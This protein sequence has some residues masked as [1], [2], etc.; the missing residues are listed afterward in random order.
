[1]SAHPP[2]DSF[3]PVPADPAFSAYASAAHHALVADRQS[4]SAP[5]SSDSFSPRWYA[6][7]PI[8]TPLI[9]FGML[10]F[11]AAGLYFVERRLI[12]ATGESLALMAAG[13][14]DNIDRLMLERYV[15][16]QMMTKTLRTRPND[17]TFLNNYIA[18]TKESYPVYSWLGVTDA[19]GVMIATS[20][21]TILGQNLSGAQWFQS[22]RWSNGPRLNDVENY[23]TAGGV[24]SVGFSAPITDQAGTFLGAVTTRVGLPVIEDVV[25]QTLRAFANRG[26][27]HEGLEYQVLTKEGTAFI[28]SDLFHKG[29][30]NL[31]NLGLP[32]AR[33]SASPDPGYVEEKHVRRHEPVITG[34]A[35][36]RGFDEFPELKWRVL[37]RLDRSALLAPINKV[38]W[39]LSVAGAVVLAPL[40]GFL[41]LTTRRLHREWRHA[42]EAEASERLSEVRTRLLLETALDAIIMLDPGGRVTAWNNQAE[43]TFGWTRDEAIGQDMSQLIIPAHYREAHR[44]GLLRYLTAGD[45]SMLYKR[46]ELTAHDRRGREF[47]V[48]MTV[49]PAR[50]GSMIFF[51]AFIREI[52]ERKQAERRLACQYAVASVLAEAHSVTEATPRI[53]EAVCRGLGGWDLAVLWKVDRETDVLRCASIWPSTM[54][55]DR[56][57]ATQTRQTTFARGVGLPGRVWQSRQPLWIEDV[58]AD[59]N[60]P[61]APFA[62]QAGLHGGLAF[63]ICLG[64]EIVGVMEF[65]SHEIRESEME[66]LHTLTTIGGQIGQCLTREQDQLRLRTA[67]EEAQCAN[68]AKSEFVANM[69]HEIRTPMNGI[70]GMTELLLDTSLSRDQY[71][72]AKTV[73]ASAEALLV[74]LND[75]LDFSKIEA[76]KLDLHP[77]PLSLRDTLSDALSAVALRAHQKGIELIGHVKPDVP[78]HLIGDP[79]RLRQI[80]INL[81]GN[82]LK[83]TEHGEVVVEVAAMNDE[84]GTINKQSKSE[85]S[86]SEVHR[87]S[88]ITLRFSVRDTG[89][90]IPIEQQRRIFDAFT[91][92]D[93][94]TTRKYGGTGLGLTITRK[95]VEMMGGR[96]F[97]ESQ[98]GKGST[99]TFTACFVPQPAS[100][101]PVVTEAPALAGLPVLVVDD[102]DTN[103]RILMELLGNWK[104]RPHAVHSGEAALAALSA[105]ASDAPYALCVLDVQMPEMDGWTLA[106]RIR[107]RPEG[108]DVGIL[109][110]TSEGTNGSESRAQAL[111][112]VAVL[113]KPIRQ[114][115][116]LDA[117][118]KLCARGGYGSLPT[119]VESN[120]APRREATGP[121]PNAG[122]RLAILLV[123]DNVVNQRLALRLLEKDGHSVTIAENGLDAL[124]LFETQTVDLILMD[125][126]MPVMDGFEAT[127]AIRAREAQ[128]SEASGVRGEVT[129]G[130]N[131]SS[132]LTPHASPLSP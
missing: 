51:G 88:F 70:L 10:L 63:P 6:W 48:E 30:V 119:L 103:L 32:S 79:V 60:F 112:P 37:V 102:N 99:F 120:T 74:I 86:A 61:R 62:S 108:R 2:N 46:V 45:E 12:A 110:L 114:S 126:Q 59:P 35:R 9:V 23:E 4:F 44:Q 25:T 41:Y 76:G 17:Q 67:M 109:M 56:P 96:I 128:T 50:L 27:F 95:L 42:T 84:S 29:G 72:Y 24:E 49:T 73:Q 8:V 1:M 47:P 7:L 68:R 90:G 115:Q 55:R 116:L 101:Q 33:L 64:H 107:Q 40:L 78:D 77:V 121:S 71:E 80:L 54:Y 31:V 97:V 130:F 20:D 123:E 53:M 57:F 122:D 58:M 117:I 52:T 92:A 26:G 113:H 13:I 66:V 85:G 18:W 94:T 98:P 38:L 65:F 16:A 93:G 69:S 81:V 21:S 118:L 28:D 89:I 83:F 131:S 39:I 15:D 104:L 19:A 22:A 125:V 124:K 106:G 75:I 11:Y 87:S 105:A 100:A 91:Q 36:T 5:A 43:Q 129:S 34:Y 111:G 82:A 132:R 127:R 14:A 3:H